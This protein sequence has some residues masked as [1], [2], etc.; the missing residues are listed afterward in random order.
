MWKLKLS[1][2]NDS[3]RLKSLNNHIGRQ[4]WEFDSNLGTAEE[5]AQVEK[6]Q[7]GFKENRFQVKQSSDLLM[8]FQF[9]KENP[10]E[11]EPGDRVKVENEEEITEEAVTTVLRRGLRFYSTLQAEDGFWP[12]DYGGPLFLLPGL[13][14]KED[15]D[16]T[17]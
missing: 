4:Y 11:I 15:Q 13:D 10:C 5:R 9:A 2:G 7:D 3:W 16:L 14:L 8:R 12:G 1:E 17:N 6:A